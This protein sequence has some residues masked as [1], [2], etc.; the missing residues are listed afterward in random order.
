M[1]IPLFALLVLAGAAIYFMTPAERVR[2]AQAALLSIKRGV[3]A[4]RHPSASTEP[5]DVW[6]HTRT[7]LVIV[8]PLL[9]A[10]HLLV[11]T[12]M[13]FGS[14]A[15]GDFQTVIAWGANQAPRTTNGEWWRLVAS[16]FVHGG[17][18]HLA[19]TLA[20]LIPLGLVLERA[21]GR[22]AFAATYLAAGT[23]ASVVSLWTIPAVDVSF[24]AS[25]AI[26]GLYGLLLA[27]VVWAIF[28]RPENK[29]PLLTIKR[30]AAAAAV[31]VLYNLG[32]DH[33]GTAAELTGLGTGLF[34]GLLI[35]RGV[36]REKPAIRRAAVV[37]AVAAAVAIVAALPLRGIIDVRPEIAKIALLEQR[38]AS[39]YDA[40]VEQFKLGRLPPKRLA[41]VIDRTILPDLQA[42]RSSLNALRG[43][44]REQAP[45][46]AAADKYFTLREQSWRRRAEGLLRANINILRDAERTER[47]ALDVFQTFQP[48]S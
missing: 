24:G 21:V 47:A 36:T 46:V 9:I 33:L 8:T 12:L 32:T 16:T 39:A 5:F 37:V 34:A 40:A 3:S 1:P 7:R 27:S 14:G 48:A 38:T 19:A 26:F 42:V 20:G 45:L 35:S 18:F 17:V 2:L 25:G 11:F 31:F 4:A 23:L 15:I 43:V 30:L 6:L 41:Q 10:L 13:L 22:V 29:I 44:P 28:N